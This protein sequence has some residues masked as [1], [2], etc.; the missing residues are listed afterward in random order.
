MSACPSCPQG[1]HL[2]IE[3]YLRP[4]TRQSPLRFVSLADLTVDVSRYASLRDDSGRAA[5]SSLIWG[6]IRAQNIRTSAVRN[7]DCFNCE[8]DPS[9]L[10]CKIWSTIIKIPKPCRRPTFLAAFKKKK[11]LWRLVELCMNN[12]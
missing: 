7:Q 4:A 5:H 8:I 12:P 1:S 2:R 9:H 11:I 10:I 6:E 3:A